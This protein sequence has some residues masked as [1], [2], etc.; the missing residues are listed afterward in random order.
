M[1]NQNLKVRGKSKK[2]ICSN[3]IPGGWRNSVGYKIRKDTTKKQF[4]KDVEKYQEGVKTK[5][6]RKHG[7]IAE[8]QYSIPKLEKVEPSAPPLPKRPKN[9]IIPK[10]KRK[11]PPIP[12]RKPALP[13]RKPP[14]IP[15]SKPTPYKSKGKA[16]PVPKRKPPPIPKSKPAPFRRKSKRK[17]PPIPKSKPTP[18]KSKG[19]AP[20]IP[21]RKKTKTIQV[22]LTGLGKLEN[23]NSNVHRWEQSNKT[24]VR[25]YY[26]KEDKVYYDK[27]TTELGALTKEDLISELDSLISELGPKL[28]GKNA[29]HIRYKD[30]EI[31]YDDIGVLFGIVDKKLKG[32]KRKMLKQLS[33]AALLFLFGWGGTKIAIDKHQKIVASTLKNIDN[34]TLKKIV[35]DEPDFLYGLPLSTNEL[36]K[37]SDEVVDWIDIHNQNTDTWVKGHEQW[38]EGFVQNDVEKLSKITNNKSSLISQVLLNVTRAQNIMNGRGTTAIGY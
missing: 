24:K 35:I 19:K 10:A 3:T 2:D 11:P 1:L 34:T 7:T 12:S 30:V 20:P 33:G 5:I 23:Q 15:K 29:Y 4:C 31:R 22:F 25:V 18:Y 28:T 26:D 16:P 9:P 13:K 38:V 14:S 21:T 36:N 27:E 32:K 6:A 17:P 37:I 8:I